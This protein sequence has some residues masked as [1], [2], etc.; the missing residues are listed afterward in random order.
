MKEIIPSS[1][2]VDESGGSL[3]FSVPISKI[4][5]ISPMFKL[6]QKGSVIINSKLNELQD[7]IIDC[8]ISQTTLEEV[9]MKVTGKKIAKVSHTNTLNDT[10]DDSN[11]S[12]SF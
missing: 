8:G 10:I 6:V 1:N 11:R 5:E 4:T 12:D 2:L 9:F 3:I 7:L